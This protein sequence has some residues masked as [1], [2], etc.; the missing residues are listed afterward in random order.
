LPS[1]KIQEVV[2]GEEIQTGRTFEKYCYLS[3]VYPENSRVGPQKYD[4]RQ[5]ISLQWNVTPD[6]DLR[7]FQISEMP[8]KALKA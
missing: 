8:I 5:F 3:N 7:T 6:Y 2:A 4:L 1:R